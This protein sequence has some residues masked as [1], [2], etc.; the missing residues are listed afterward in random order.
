MVGG[1]APGG[2]GSEE[3]LPVEVMGTTLSA[4]GEVH[5]TEET[6]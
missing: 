4:D 1:A 6:S 5:V 2:P 3:V